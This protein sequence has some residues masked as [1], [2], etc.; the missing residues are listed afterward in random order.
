MPSTRQARKMI[1]KRICYCS[2]HVPSLYTWQYRWKTSSPASSVTCWQ[3][4]LS[5]VL[6]AALVAG[7]ST[8][9]VSRTLSPC[10]A[11]SSAQLLSLV[12]VLPSNWACCASLR[13]RLLS[14]QG[15]MV[16]CDS[17][18]RLLWLSCSSA[19]AC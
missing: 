1:V 2:L 5:V 15:T 16:S 12:T 18:M 3:G 9:S 6:S 17:N 14:L 7:S 19:H 4:P 10:G 11:S 13:K 8:E